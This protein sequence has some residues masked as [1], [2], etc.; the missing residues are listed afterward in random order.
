MEE[1][2]NTEFYAQA[3]HRTIFHELINSPHLPPPEKST[4][5]I[6]Q[7]AGAMVG[8]GGESTSQ[9]LTVMIYCLI[10]APEKMKKLRD[11]LR[12]VM[13]SSDSP[14]PALK[15]LEALPYL[16]GKPLRKSKNKRSLTSN[17]RLDASEKH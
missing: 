11:E 4:I 13:P 17:L 10:A 3:G 7:E 16:V 12:T 15:Q 1:E 8:A 14:P 2:K 5:R 9:T 6:I